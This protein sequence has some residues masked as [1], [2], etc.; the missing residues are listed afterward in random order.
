MKAQIAERKH[1]KCT[2][3]GMAVSFFRL[4]LFK[5]FVADTLTRPILGPPVILFWIS[6]DVSSG[7]QSQSGLPYSLCTSSAT[8]C[9]PL[10]GQHCGSNLSYISCVLPPPLRSFGSATGLLSR[11][12]ELNPKSKFGLLGEWFK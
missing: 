12:A 3:S 7:F 5:M 6:G 9:Q 11:I 1:N 2:P 8:Y 4:A 10:D